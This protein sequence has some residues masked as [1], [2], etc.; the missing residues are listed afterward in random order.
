MRPQRPVTLSTGALPTCK[1]L[2]LCDPG[3]RVV[4]LDAPADPP[5]DQP[6]RRLSL[7]VLGISIE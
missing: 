4:Y 2:L 5:P 7:A 1:L 3:E 6:T